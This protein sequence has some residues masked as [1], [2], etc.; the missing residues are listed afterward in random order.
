MGEFLVMP[1]KSGKAFAS[2]HNKKL[3]G[4]AADVAKSQAE[5]LIKKGIP[6]GEAIATAN[7]TGDRVQSR[8][9]KWY[10]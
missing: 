9:K 2:K 1:W 4:A 3:T 5:A 7:K 6:E 8:H 10:G